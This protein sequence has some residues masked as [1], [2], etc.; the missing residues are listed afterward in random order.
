M[1]SIRISQKNY[2][3]LKSIMN[4]RSWDH[5]LSDLVYPHLCTNDNASTAPPK[6]VPAIVSRPNEPIMIAP[7]R[8]KTNDKNHLIDI[9]DNRIVFITIRDA[10]KVARKLNLEA[11]RIAYMPVNDPEDHII[12]MQYGLSSEE[13][14]QESIER[15]R[16]EELG[17]Q[18]FLER[19]RSNGIPSQPGCASH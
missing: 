6:P 18:A 10:Q 15:K 3:N 19:T 1:P 2:D 16:A 12:F 8:A 17:Y 9:N 14:Q 5:L 11:G 4:G 7:G 13:L